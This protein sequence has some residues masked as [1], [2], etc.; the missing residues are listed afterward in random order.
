MIDPD[1]LDGILSSWS[2][3]A[4][5]TA[6][7]AAPPATPKASVTSTLPSP[8]APPLQAAPAAP[9]AATPQPPVTTTLPLPASASPAVIRAPSVP[10]A[11]ASPPVVPAPPEAPEEALP[12]VAAAA[13]TRSRTILAAGALSLAA[14]AAVWWFLAPGAPRPPPASPPADPAA[15]TVATAPKATEPPPRAA[16]T[17]A[18][19]F[20]SAPGATAAPSAARPP[21]TDS[22]SAAPVT[23][24]A[25]EPVLFGYGSPVPRIEPGEA[26]RALARRVSACPGRI[27]L[28]GHTCDIGPEGAN[29]ALGM[30]RAARVRM[31]LVNDG[32]DKGRI[33]V[34]STGKAEPTAANSSEDARARNRRVTVA[35]E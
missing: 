9:H 29:R 33:V 13:P 6:A 25:F 14:A 31:L 16:S 7:R 30:E 32:V 12:P 24:G 11:T 2:V 22:E 3:T 19:T 18:P 1:G 35:C 21:R 8:G 10:P 15:M 26:S 27:L 5:V 28:T 23:P 20:E 4:P 17:P 34:R